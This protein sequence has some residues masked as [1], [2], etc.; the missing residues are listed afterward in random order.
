MWWND[1]NTASEEELLLAVEQLEAAKNDGIIPKN[2]D[3][4]CIVRYASFKINREGEDTFGSLQSS[5]LIELVLE[6]ILEAQR[7]SLWT[8]P[9][10][11]T[12]SAASLRALS[13]N[14]ECVQLVR[15]ALFQ[16]IRVNK[17]ALKEA[18]GAAQDIGDSVA[19][20][21]LSAALEDLKT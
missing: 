2:D 16:G 9:S 5:Q 12:S 19:V 3:L 11:I 15:D 21:E 6:A 1:P 17:R 7:T 8:Q 14:K 4:R 10:F 20:E 18:L 13:A